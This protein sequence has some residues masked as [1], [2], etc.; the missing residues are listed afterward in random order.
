VNR[1]GRVTCPL[2][3]NLIIAVFNAKEVVTKYQSNICINNEKMSGTITLYIDLQSTINHF[4]KYLNWQ[5]EYQL[6]TTA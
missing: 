3:A 4:P 2:L 6:V 1:V 5:P